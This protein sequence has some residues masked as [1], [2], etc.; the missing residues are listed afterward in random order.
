MLSKISTKP[1]KVSDIASR[2]NIKNIVQLTANS[3]YITFAA[4]IFVFTTLLYDKIS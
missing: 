1:T 3:N 2:L 4:G